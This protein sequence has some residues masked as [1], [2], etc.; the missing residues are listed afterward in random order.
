MNHIRVVTQTWELSYQKGG[1]YHVIV[2]SSLGKA[3]SYPATG[4]SIYV[5]TSL[6]R[7]RVLT[8]ATSKQWSPLSVTYLITLAK[9]I[10]YCA[11]K[12]CDIMREKDRF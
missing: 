10:V 11:N 3:T 1:I 6:E 7:K 12:T 9:L 5:G 8:P 2:K 4:R